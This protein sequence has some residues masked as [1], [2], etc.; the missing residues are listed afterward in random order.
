M[1]ITQDETQSI[2]NAVIS[3]IRTN[4]RTIDQLT[5][6][7]SLSDSDC[8]EINDGKKV[9]YKVL[10]E[11]IA[12]L[13]Q[14]ELDSLITL[15]N[16]SKLKS[17]SITVDGNSATLTIS[18]ISKDISCSIPMATLSQA[19]L[20]SADDKSLLSSVG[21]ANGLAPLGPDGKVPAANLPA[22]SGAGVKEVIEFAAIVSGIE[23]IADNISLSSTSNRC[24]VVY[25]AD[26]DI[27]L[28]RFLRISSGGFQPGGDLIEPP[29]NPSE[30]VMPADLVS[31]E[32]SGGEVNPTPPTLT[33]YYYRSW[34]DAGN[35]GS[36]TAAGV[37]STSG[38]IYVAT[39]NNALYISKNS[40]LVSVSGGES[41][42]LDRIT[43][44][45]IDEM[46]K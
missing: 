45:E 29:M 28:L 17:C 14:N 3:A 5:P 38:R 27:F 6:V 34:A 2:I 25:D 31:G 41:S 13:S 32:I 36:I 21:K 35:Y 7:T 1:A 23:D 18:S 39:A 40:K 26:R 12:A 24:A 20:I 4:S 9:T 44:S 46:F 10:K 16:R 15:I 42:E 43:E 19:G 8:F 11:L 22:S 30:A 37:K 33:P